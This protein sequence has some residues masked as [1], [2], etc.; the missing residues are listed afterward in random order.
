[1]DDETEKPKAIEFLCRRNAISIDIIRGSKQFYRGYVPKKLWPNLFVGPWS[2]LLRMHLEVTKE[3]SSTSY[4]N[5]RSYR[6]DHPTLVEM[7]YLAWSAS[8]T[9][10]ATSWCWIVV[11]K[12]AKPQLAEGSI[13]EQCQSR[14]P[15]CLYEIFWWLLSFLIVILRWIFQCHQVWLDTSHPSA[16][17]RSFQKVL[18]WRRHAP[19]VPWMKRRS[20]VSS[21]GGLFLGPKWLEKCWSFLGF[22]HQETPWTW[23]LTVDLM[24]KRVD[25]TQHL[26]F[27][28][29]FLKYFCDETAELLD[30]HLP[31]N[32]RWHH[33]IT[34]IPKWPGRLPKIAASESQSEFRIDQFYVIIHPPRFGGKSFVPMRRS[35]VHR[36][37][38][39]FEEVNTVT[40]D[41][42]SIVT[43]RTQHWLLSFS[44]GM[45]LDWIWKTATVI[46]QDFW[47]ISCF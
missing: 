43:A 26:R 33:S 39:S 32:A 15:L 21:P 9:M 3:W 34:K 2:G 38:S 46:N 28:S 13:I 19:H 31:L 44:C 8:L 29:R 23:R 7:E 45:W 42:R 12:I 18:T 17:I 40:W 16:L 4:C 47:S 25:T 10:Q 1:M 30:A 14:L 27:F 11:L 24:V 36:R 41:E 20:R 6:E 35:L 22:G 5:D 37:T